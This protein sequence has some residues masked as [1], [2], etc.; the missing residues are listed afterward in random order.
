M[1]EVVGFAYLLGVAVLVLGPPIV[2]RRRGARWRW[3]ALGIASWTVALLA[4]LVV[5]GVYATLRPNSA[6]WEQGVWY[7]TVSAVCELGMTALLLR[8]PLPTADVLAFGAGIGSFEIVFKIGSAAAG[9]QSLEAAAAA[10]APHAAALLI[11]LAEY[12]ACLVLHTAER[13]LVHETFAPRR[14]APA[15]IAFAIFVVVDG[16]AAY[17]SAAGWDWRSDAVYGSY[18]GF[19]ALLAAVAA[20]AARRLWRPPAS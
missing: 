20:V 7:G 8:P 13:V 17:G 19:V 9:A 10:T 4:K 12:A 11:G 16:L 14:A 3:F 18:I 15:L 5:N 2:L 1:D 6:P